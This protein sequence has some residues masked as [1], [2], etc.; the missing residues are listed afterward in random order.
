MIYLSAYYPFTINKTENT[1]TKLL[2]MA[3][4][5][6]IPAA[7]YVIIK[8]KGNAA[9]DASP[10]EEIAAKTTITNAYVGYLWNP[11]QNNLLPYVFGEGN[12]A[13]STGPVVSTIAT[14]IS[15]E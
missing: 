6:K 1:T 15:Q 9:F 14:P 3:S 11:Y 13:L 2:E 4:I 12:S 7:Q 10:Q 8:T 5:I